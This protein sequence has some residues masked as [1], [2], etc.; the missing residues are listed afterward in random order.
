MYAK[1]DS[2]QYF[3]DYNPYISKALYIGGL[4]GV[5]NQFPVRFMPAPDGLEIKQLGH[6]TPKVIFLAKKEIISVDVENQTTIDSRVSLGRFMAVGVFA[7]A[8]KKKSTVP[9]SYL[10]ITYRNDI[11]DEQQ[12]L[13]QSEEKQGFQ[14]FTNIRYNLLK[15]WKVIEENPSLANGLKLQQ[16]DTEIAKDKSLN[17]SSKGC[18]IAFIVLVI[19][20]IIIGY[21]TQK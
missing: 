18:M 12:I 3:L 20:T 9:L 10:V 13:F 6:T 8:W 17:E 2:Y 4:P 1:I 7:L 5:D 11:G 16:L 21:V 14:D 15:F 19:I